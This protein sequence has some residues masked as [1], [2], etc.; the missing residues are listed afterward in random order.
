M[1]P[2]KLF[3][4]FRRTAA[5]DIYPATKDEGRSRRSLDKNGCHVR[6]YNIVVNVEKAEA[7]RARIKI[8]KAA[9]ADKMS[10]VAK[11][12]C[13]WLRF[14]YVISRADLIGPVNV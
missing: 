7:L 5:R 13:Q 14:G 9:R 2:S 6:R 10:K 11:F 8:V 12:Q 3:H 1:V 4:D